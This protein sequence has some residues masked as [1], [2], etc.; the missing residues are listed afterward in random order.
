MT[1][2]DGLTEAKW[3]TQIVTPK[4]I[5]S[6]LWDINLKVMTNQLTFLL[7]NIDIDYNFI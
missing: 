2:C 6:I 5:T 1:L 7:T 3:L 4:E